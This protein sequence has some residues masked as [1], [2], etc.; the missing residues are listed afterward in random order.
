VY[1]HAE[2]LAGLGDDLLLFP[3]LSF[4]LSVVGRVGRC[5]LSHEL[6]LL[7]GLSRGVRHKVLDKEALKTAAKLAATYL[8]LQEPLFARFLLA[9]ARS[10][11]C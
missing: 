6:F 9:T 3:L 8:T 5:C 2:L 7:T 4:Q 11:T 1:L 10:P